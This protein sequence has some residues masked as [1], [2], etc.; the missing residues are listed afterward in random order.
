MVVSSAARSATVVRAWIRALKVN[1]RP[2][3]SRTY[4]RFIS[5][6][7]WTHRLLPSEQV[8]RQIARDLR[9]A[10]SLGV[11]SSEEATVAVKIGPIHM[12]GHVTGPNSMTSQFMGSGSGT[13]R[14][15][16]TE[17][18]STASLSGIA[19]ETGSEMAAR[20]TLRLGRRP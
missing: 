5:F 16:P 10:A 12:L 19:P 8:A 4:I 17:A 13:A 6:V 11:V 7:P 15:E 9:L 1:R 18:F 20:L 14:L 2:S 3:T